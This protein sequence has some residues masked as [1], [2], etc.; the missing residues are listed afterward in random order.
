MSQQQ[1]GFGAEYSET[2]FWDKLAKFA[3]AAGREVIELALQLYYAMQAPNTPSWAKAVIIAALGYFISP[4]DAIP[5]VMPVVG[6][7]DDLGVLTAALA[8]V[9]SY[10]TDD[11]KQKAQA[12]CAEW[13][14]Q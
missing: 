6:Y 3:F 10:I 8:T 2:S 14:G 5:D 13:F 9:T 4:I 1:A 12:K 11:I 7:A